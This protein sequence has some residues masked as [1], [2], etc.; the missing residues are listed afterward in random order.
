MDA[1]EQGVTILVTIIVALGGK[2]LLVQWQKNKASKEERKEDREDK[3]LQKTE[4]LLIKR[5]DELQTKLDDRRA[6][7]D[8][9][10]ENYA[11][12]RT[13]LDMLMEEITK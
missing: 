3:A 12:C 2:E 8:E 1:L 7:E 6:V 13:K 5:V 4:E 9:L 11:S 10:R